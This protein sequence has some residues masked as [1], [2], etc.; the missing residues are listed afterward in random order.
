VQGL[1]VDTLA[2]TPDGRDSCQSR[3]IPKRAIADLETAVALQPHYRKA[4]TELARL[5]A[6]DGQREKAV[7]ASAKE[8]A[9][10]HRD[11]DENER[12]LQQVRAL[13]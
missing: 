7:A 10:V 8:R 3:T 9:E 13:P 11:E 6:A 4:Y 1:S 12:M 2:F 5:Y